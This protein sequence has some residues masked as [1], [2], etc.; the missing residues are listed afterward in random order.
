M[1]QETDAARCSMFQVVFTTVSKESDIWQRQQYC[2]HLKETCSSI[3]LNVEMTWNKHTKNKTTTKQIKR[4]REVPC[5]SAEIQA[6]STWFLPLLFVALARVLTS[7]TD[8]HC[9]WFDGSQVLRQ[10]ADNALTND[11]DL[12]AFEVDLDDTSDRKLPF[13]E[14]FVTRNYE[15]QRIHS[16]CPRFPI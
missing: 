16:N 12:A 2:I 5:K 8:D 1:T 10:Q 7:S 11:K 14:E 6:S 15:I 3:V 9:R 13:R 4:T